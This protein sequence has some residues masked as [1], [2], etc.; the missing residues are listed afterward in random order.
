MMKYII[1]LL[2]AYLMLSNLTAQNYS[3]DKDF[4]FSLS[5]LTAVHVHNHTGQ[6]TI[7]GTNA[8]EGKITL[9]RNL[10]SASNA[11][12]AK[13]KEIIYLDSMQH[14]GKL[15]FFIHSPTHIFKI[16]ENGRG[17]YQSP[18][19]NWSGNKQERFDVEAEFNITL[20]IPKA[21]DLYASTHEKDLYISNISG[22]VFAKNHHDQ[23]VLTGLRNNLNAHAHH[24]DIKV[25]FAANPERSIACRT[26]HGDIKVS[27]APGLSADIKMKSHHGSFFTDF[28]YQIVATQV[29]RKEENKTGTKYTIG[30]GTNV[31]IGQGGL[32]MDFRT[33]HGDVYVTKN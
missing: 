15:Y 5:G 10:K 14:E 17:Y 16:D 12:L 26:H 32:Q 31:R 23:V 19:N 8:Q 6:V 2:F 27:M 9:T 24:G 7:N 18:W 1:T 3:A 30:D 4:I 13:A 29:S 22:E 21:M 33:H 20:E 11:A 28:D 25:E